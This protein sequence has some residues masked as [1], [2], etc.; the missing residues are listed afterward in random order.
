MEEMAGEDAPDKIVDGWRNG[1]PALI[2]R[3]TDV[4]KKT[5][6]GISPTNQERT[7]RPKLGNGSSASDD[8]LMAVLCLGGVSCNPIF[9][10][11]NS[12]RGVHRSVVPRIPP[13]PPLS[14][15]PLAN[16]QL[17]RREEGSSKSAR[18]GTRDLDGTPVAR[19]TS[20]I[21]TRD[22]LDFSLASGAQ[23]ETASTEIRSERQSGRGY[24]E[25]RSF[26]A[27][28]KTKTMHRPLSIYGKSVVR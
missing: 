4:G 12:I 19:I 15:P 3:W 5:C 14:S 11:T 10:N 21:S 7:F 13:S 2:D 27:C 20:G 8:D 17:G 9:D 18:H 28:P 6:A 22:V 25:H 1:R 16:T 26:L 24:F 23:I